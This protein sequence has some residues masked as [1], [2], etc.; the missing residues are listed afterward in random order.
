[1]KLSFILFFAISFIYCTE[2]SPPKLASVPEDKTMSTE[3]LT[4]ELI[5]LR[6]QVLRQEEAIRKL[7]EG[8]PTRKRSH[9]SSSD[10]DY[11]STGSMSRSGSED[12]LTDRLERI[13]ANTSPLS[14]K[15]WTSRRDD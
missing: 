6:M 10:D 5:A 13:S 15:R 4:K 3:E 11:K 2:D 8:K 12:S 1:M 7:E 9:S 14:P